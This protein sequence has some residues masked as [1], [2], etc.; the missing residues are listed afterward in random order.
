MNSAE[1]KVG[2]EKRTLP[3]LPLRGKEFEFMGPNLHLG[4][5]GCIGLRTLESM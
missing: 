4:Q 3:S 5:S 2:A 1:L